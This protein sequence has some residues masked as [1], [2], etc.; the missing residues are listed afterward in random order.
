MNNQLI[1][2][3]KAT[4]YTASPMRKTAWGLLIIPVSLEKG[5]G[6]VVTG[7]P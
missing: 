2:H 5:Q 4:L 7:L 6:E 1:V 3:D